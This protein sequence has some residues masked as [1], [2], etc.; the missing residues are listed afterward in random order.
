MLAPVAPVAF[1]PVYLL[2]QWCTG[3]AQ[4]LIGAFKKKLAAWLR[5]GVGGYLRF[6][7]PV[8]NFLL[9][10]LRGILMGR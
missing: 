7:Y 9:V 2:L 1:F 8:F 4:T 5:V 10:R 6:P 3:R